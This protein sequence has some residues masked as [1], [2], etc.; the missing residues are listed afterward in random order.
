MVLS[1]AT[2]IDINRKS[3][4]LTPPCWLV[5][6][7]GDSTKRRPSGEADADLLSVYHL[8]AA[9]NRPETFHDTIKALFE[10]HCGI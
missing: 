4:N 2:H 10:L 6:R 8:I 5:D 1:E 7:A 9:G 3:T